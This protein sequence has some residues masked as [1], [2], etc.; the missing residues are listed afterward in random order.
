MT[1]SN[2]QKTV[3]NIKQFLELFG[4]DIILTRSYINKNGELKFK[5]HITIA[6]AIKYNQ[7]PHYSDVYFRPNQGGTHD[8]DINRLNSLFIDLDAGKDPTS[9]RYYEDSTVLSI[10]QEFL[11]KI[12]SFIYTPSIIIETRNGYHCYWLLTNRDTIISTDWNTAEELL[13]N[14]FSADKAVKNPSRLMRLPYLMWN[15]EW[16]GLAPFEV[17]VETISDISY[18]LF[19][20]LTHLKTATNIGTSAFKGDKSDRR[21]SA[22]NNNSVNTQLVLLAPNQNKEKGAL[23]Q[24]IAMGDAAFIARQLSID[25]ENPK[26]FETIYQANEWI[27]ANVNMKDLLGLPNETNFSCI[28]HDDRKPSATV[29]TPEQSNYGVYMYVCQSSNCSFTSGN[30]IECVAYLQKTTYRKAYLFLYN[31]YNIKVNNSE[32]HNEQIDIIENNKF[33]LYNGEFAAKFP[34]TYSLINRYPQRKE[35]LRYMLDMAKYNICGE[36]RTDKYGRPIFF[37]SLRWMAEYFGNKDP[38]RFSERITLLAALGLINK[39]PDSD[40]PED[41]LCKAKEIQRKKRYKYTIQFYSIPDYTDEFTVATIRNNT[42]EWKAKGMTIKGISYDCFA[43]SYG[44][45]AADSICPKSAGKNLTEYSENFIKNMKATLSDLIIK[46]GYSTE[47]QMLESF[48]GYKGVN[49]KKSK[50]FLF[51]VLESLEL[52]RVRCTKKIKKKHKIKEDI[53]SSA[54]VIVRKNYSRKNR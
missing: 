32:W 35:L 33:L 21:F 4:N 38:K 29:L 6:E 26:L 13:V 51:S 14:Y 44:I 22:N 2:E 11:K 7:K 54:Y 34:D 49:E 36:N 27:N 20:M 41:W 17:K 8:K 53:G 23:R 30:I 50:M 19:E 48:K 45:E 42:Q 15:K 25:N 18:D 52:E 39:I 12:N 46:N 43:L 24:A 28:F 37:V 16:T 31:L 5:Q 47:K 9:N 10:K 1:T 40:I 3:E